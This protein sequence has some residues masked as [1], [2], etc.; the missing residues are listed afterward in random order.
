MYLLLQ[1]GQR[2]K[3]NQEYL[4]LLA[5]LQELYLFVKKYGLILNQELNSIKLIQ[6]QKE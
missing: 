5:H 3:Q 4:P 2:L 6:W 1:A